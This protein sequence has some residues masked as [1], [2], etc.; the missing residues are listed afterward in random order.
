MQ[1][2]CSHRRREAEGGAQVQGQPGQQEL[3]PQEEKTEWVIY[4]W[5]IYLLR[6]YFRE[7][8]EFIREKLFS[9]LIYDER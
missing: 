9:F 8:S 2:V 6:K 5:L 7:F 4:K 1:E 3:L